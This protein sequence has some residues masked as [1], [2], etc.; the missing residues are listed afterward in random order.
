M[1]D[2]EHSSASKSQGPHALSGSSERPYIPTLAV[3]SPDNYGKIDA[4]NES[5][6][7][8]LSG[9][10]SPRVGTVVRAEKCPDK[11]SI[12]RKRGRSKSEDTKSGMQLYF[13]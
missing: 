7:S 13:S 8:I 9:V 2:D 5:N 12:P 6:L 11:S 4:E 1:A 10:H 3:T